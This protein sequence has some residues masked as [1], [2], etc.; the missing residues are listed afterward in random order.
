M[1]I[2]NLKP[3]MPKKTKTKKIFI[4]PSWKKTIKKI[5]IISGVAGL[6]LFLLSIL[7]I[8]MAMAWIS[9]DL[10][11]P[12]TLLNRD[13]PQST[14][15]FDR[16]GKVLL[17]EIHGDEKRTLVKIEDI[18][19]SVKFATIS[20]EDRKFYEHHGINWGRILK[21]LYYDV[22]HRRLAQGASTLTQ[23]LVKNAILTNEKSFERKFKEILIALQIERNF[24][25][26]QILQMYLNEI[27]Y[28]SSIYGVE[29]ASET[30]FGK[31]ASELTL[32]EAALLASI[33][34]A[35]DL[36]NPYGI[37]LHGDN[38][39][40]LVRRQRIALDSM[41]RDGY[42]TKQEA[43]NAKKIKT[44]D[45]LIPRKIQGI[46][47]P[48]FVMYIRSLLINRYGQKTVEQGGLNVITS[49][50]WNLQQMAE[51]DVKKG[52]ERNGERYG[53]TNGALLSLDPKSG[54]VL[55]MVGSKDF[56]DKDI[57]GQV[58]VTLRP[59]QPGSSF[60]PIVYTAGFIKGYTP[61]TVLWDVVTPF[62]TG[63][64]TYL[65]QN[66]SFSYHG[67]LTVRKA[68]QGSLNIPAVKMLYLV[69]VDRA[70][71]FAQQLGYTTL[72]DR[73]RFGLALVLGGGEVK[74]IEHVNAFATFANQG[75]QFPITG[76]LK[77]TDAKGQVL[78]EWSPTSGKQVIPKQAA[79]QITNVL[80]DNNARAYVFGTHSPLILQDRQVAAKTGTT[81]NNKDA[82]TIGYTPNIVTAVWMGN[83]SGQEMKRGADGSVI[84]A[85]VWQS[86]MKQATKTFTKES[87]EKP[88]P[89]KTTKPVLLGKSFKTTL[90]IDKVS[91]KIATA[92]TPPELVEEKTFYEGHTI[93]H[94]LD[95]DDPLGNT[96]PNFKD[97]MYTPWEH[98]VQAW[99]EK[100]EWH[101]T[102]TAPTSTD[103]VHTEANKPSVSILKPINNQNITDRDFTIHLSM[104]AQRG[105]SKI[106]VKI[107]DKTIATLY[108]KTGLLNVRIPNSIV[109]GYH[110]LTVTVYDDVENNSTATVNIKLT[111]DLNPINVFLNNPTPGEEI[112]L[113]SFPY[114][115]SFA[116]S[117]L[118]KVNKVD[119]RYEKGGISTLIGS[120]IAPQNYNNLI[121]WKTPPATGKIKIYPIIYR[122]DGSIIRGDKITI[123]I[124]P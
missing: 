53:F 45:K 71:D 41:V 63:S 42:I 103:D 54:Q 30:Y 8:T 14:K 87:F 101:T 121:E 62:K 65:P 7:G 95:K 79:L 46:K 32:D 38:R 68:L 77:V 78:E 19:D 52:V 50:D 64:K 83:S 37:G 86:F 81:N 104:Q 115:I 111:A 75:K 120:I 91:G 85:P 11:N 84:A 21:A 124:K 106:K 25:K 57:D 12:N 90:K 74:M 123:R 93:L 10:P 89:V 105:I 49:L 112:P 48:H 73:S 13:I 35:P 33:P 76:I 29:S 109:K 92:F 3:V 15:L 102:S 117:D 110:T 118:E 2:N 18:P 122:S 82:W 9:R 20:L 116:L 99:I 23:Q 96:P 72:N 88:E 69:G 114:P 51:E 67:P 44:L 107:D 27:P 26:D 100:Q 60:K 66:Y 59:R 80:S 6:I 28:G 22:L 16:T 47:A 113:N 4:K 1:P 24:T 34:Q 98:A 119:L 5:L 108:Q 55:A 36:Y 70:L 40:L 43:E 56:F 17:Y 31:H 61:E 97:P 94:Y 39:D 58:N